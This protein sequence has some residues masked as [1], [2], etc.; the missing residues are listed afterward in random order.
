MTVLLSLFNGRIVLIVFGQMPF[1]QSPGLLELTQ[2]TR[3][4]QSTSAISG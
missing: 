4:G 1:K 2:S 3:G